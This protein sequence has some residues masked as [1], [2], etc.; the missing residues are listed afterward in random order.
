MVMSMRRPPVALTA[1]LVVSTFLAASARPAEDAIDLGVL[2]RLRTE[3][4]ERSQVMDTASYLTDV[5]GPRLTASPNARKAADW[6]MGKMREWG[7]SAVHLETFPFGRGWQ[8]QRFVALV[9][10]PQSF[11][12]IGFPK[13]WTPGTNGPVTAEAVLA[14]ITRNEDFATWHGKLKGKIVL[15]APARD[16]PA[17]FNPRARRYTD[18]DLERITRPPAA[19]GG[20]PGA[21]DRERQTVERRK[22]QFFVEEGVAAL[23]EPS[24]RGDGGTVFVQ[25]GGPR[26]PAAAQVAPQIVL[27]VEHYDRLVRLLEKKIPVSLQLDIDSRFYDDTLD[28]FNIVGELP[29]SDKADEIV[30]LGAHFDSWQ[31]AT[32]ATDNAAGSAIMLE[33]MRILKA[34]GVPLRRTVRIG[35]WTGEEQGLIG[36]REYVTAHF[37]DRATMK[38]TPDYAKF[39]GYFNVDNGT[40]L[41]RGVYLQ[42]NDAV[43][44]IFERWM[45]PLRDG[46]M[47]TLTIRNTGGTDH[48]SFDRVG[49]P[50]FQ[51]VQDEIEYNALTHHSNMDTFERLQQDDMQRNAVIVAWF[52]YNT[53]N[54]DELLPRKEK[55]APEPSQTPQR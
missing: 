13:A 46:G 55:P 18:E 30:M 41:I 52:V 3:G 34:T 43:G 5:Y 9:T 47:T 38:V 19:R 6:T 10:A 35:L 50:G 51:F 45:A 31:S 44:P 40:G 37:A 7:L 54:R 25:G 16:V 23:V 22:P 20:G 21:P 32:G 14:V 4:T 36:S 12:L 33:A 53:A 11:P 27:A 42:G 48:L 8:N 17:A 29:G 28:A 24:P 15:T 2:S 39:A 26:D 49:L 1:V